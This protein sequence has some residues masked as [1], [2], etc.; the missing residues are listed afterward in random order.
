VTQASNKEQIELTNDIGEDLGT[1]MTR[2]IVGK[3]QFDLS[4]LDDT[5]ANTDRLLCWKLSDLSK[6]SE[7][8]S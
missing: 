3:E 4:E 2:E 5:I 8:N 6:S 1:P 7:I